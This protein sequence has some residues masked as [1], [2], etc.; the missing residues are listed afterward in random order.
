[1]ESIYGKLKYKHLVRCASN[2]F[3]DA[4]KAMLNRKSDQNIQLLKYAAGGGYL[5]ICLHILKYIPDDKVLLAEKILLTC[6]H[7]KIVKHMIKAGA[8]IKSLNSCDLRQIIFRDYYKTLKCLH[9]A[10]CSLTQIE[11][12][13]IV[14]CAVISNS[15]NKM[16]MYLAK[17][18]F[19]IKSEHVFDASKVNNT[20]FVEYALCKCGTTINNHHKSSIM[21]N[22]T[23]HKNKKMIN[24]LCKL[25]FHIPFIDANTWDCTIFYSK[26]ESLNA[27]IKI[28]SISMIEYLKTKGFTMQ[29]E[30]ARFLG[31]HG[32]LEM[33]QYFME[34]EETYSNDYR[35]QTFFGAITHYNSHVLEFLMEKCIKMTSLNIS[36]LLDH[37]IRFNNLPA[38]KFLMRYQPKIDHNVLRNICRCR[39]KIILYFKN[40]G[41]SLKKYAAVTIEEAIKQNRLKVIKYVINSGYFV[42]NIDHYS[43]KLTISQFL[44]NALK[45]KL[46]FECLTYFISI[47]IPVIFITTY[48]MQLDKKLIKYIFGLYN[49][50]QQQQMLITRSDEKTLITITK[51]NDQNMQKKNFLRKNNLFK[52]ALRP[53]NMNVIL[54]YL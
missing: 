34:T 41:W 25:N 48:N 53:T 6:K 52:M 44:C 15:Q 19:P 13:H 35:I 30:N 26:L 16:A 3:Y 22:F 43:K 45:R 2:G 40:K 54:T 28:N 5:K 7:V 10:G 31:Q 29:R 24:M 1:M 46:S 49:R 27:A 51:I 9:R 17:N 33:I 21:A 18:G 12:Q 42:Q 50:R 32:C 23:A 14:L 38:I 20:K 36:R 37:A 4:I 47:G 8:D 11:N 39:L